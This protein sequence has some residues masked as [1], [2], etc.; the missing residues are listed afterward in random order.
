M[1][2]DI[3]DGQ[4]AWWAMRPTAE[5]QDH[6]YI[7]SVEILKKR[8]EEVRRP[9]KQS[10]VMMGTSTSSSSFG[11]ISRGS[12]QQSLPNSHGYV[13]N[14]NIKCLGVVWCLVVVGVVV[15]GSAGGGIL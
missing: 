9:S 11:C 5:S 7:H 1:D 12:H 14:I 6:I 13:F 4:N 2:E 15:G 10:K 3:D 8:R